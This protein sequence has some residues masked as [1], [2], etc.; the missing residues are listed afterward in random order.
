MLDPKNLMLEVPVRLGKNV[1]YVIASPETKAQYF[2]NNNVNIE[3]EITLNTNLESKTLTAPIH[4]GEKVGTVDVVYKNEVIAS[5]DLVAKYN[6]NASSAL[7]FLDYVKKLLKSTHVRIALI[8]FAVIFVAY[9]SLSYL[10]FV[11][12]HKNKKK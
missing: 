10:S 6:V 12:S 8:V 9:L 7:R 11:R 2:L 4:E 3:T 5:V 1:D